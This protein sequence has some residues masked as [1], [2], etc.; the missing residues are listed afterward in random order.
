[1]RNI[2][3]K[4]AFSKMSLFSE[5]KDAVQKY[6]RRKS[7]SSVDIFILNN[8]SAKKVADLK[9]NYPEELS[10]LSKWLFATSFTL[11]K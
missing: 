11:K 5:K 2:A 4:L 7:S 8:S 9:S 3:E 10:I 1:M 6:L